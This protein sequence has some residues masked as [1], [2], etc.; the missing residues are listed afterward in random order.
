MIEIKILAKRPIFRTLGPNGL[1]KA[2]MSTLQ[3]KTAVFV[4]MFVILALIQISIAM[5]SKTF[6]GTIQ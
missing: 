6:F 2:M 5:N 3:N 4:S 1:V